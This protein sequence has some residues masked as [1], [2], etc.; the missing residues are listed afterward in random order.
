MAI[1]KRKILLLGAGFTTKNMGVWALAS[2]A[3]KC[4]LHTNKNAEIFLLDYYN[5]SEIYKIKNEGSIFIVKLLNIR[6]SKKI[7]LPNN[8]ARLLLT[9]A[10]I[11]LIPNQLIRKKLYSKNFWLSHI[12]T[13]NFIGS[14]SGGDSFSDIYGISRLVYVTLPQFLVLVI[15]KPLVLLPQTLGPFKGKIGRTIANYILKNSKKVYSRDREGVIFFKNINKNIEFCYD[16]G[17]ILE[18][19]IESEKIPSSIRNINKKSSIVGINI[20]GLLYIGGY[21][22]NNMFNIKVDYRRLILN[23]IEELFKRDNVNVVLIPHVIGIGNSIENDTAACKEIFKNL[24]D[25]HTESIHLVK[26]EYNHHEIKAIIGMCDFFIG[27]RMHACIAALSQFIPT[28]GLAYSKKFIGVFD[29]IN[30]SEMVI[31]LRVGET[32]E[33]VDSVMAI[34][35]RRRKIKKKL[36]LCMN[37]V[38]S[39]IL[40]LFNNN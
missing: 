40:K 25:S 29:S 27:S 17:F 22:R 9:A 23:I 14:I 34:F 11:R 19:M 13:S 3:I 24:I 32:N 7:W 16:M 1:E 26:E 20:S 39:T 15:G 36:E 4:A 31:D 37:D 8:I 18:P 21:D 2:G 28:V 5:K 38:N 33:V 10:L 30:M 35:D 6:F 12:L